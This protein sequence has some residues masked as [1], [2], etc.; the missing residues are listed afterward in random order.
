M[1]NQKRHEIAVDLLSDVLEIMAKKGEAYSEGGKE[2][3]D[4]LSNF[5]KVGADLDVTKYI[6]WAVYFEKHRH[7]IV[8]AIKNNPYKPQE[9]TEGMRG[10]VI[11]A[12]SYLC[13]LY[14]ML[15]E[16]GLEVYEPKEQV[17]EQ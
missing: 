9:R 14:S 16:D 4:V 15:V 2:G 1:T 10:R 3:G 5:K 17:S 8:H 12:I 6:V 11:D 7:A 13:I